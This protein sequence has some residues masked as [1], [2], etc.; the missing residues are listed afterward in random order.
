MS[1][2]WFIVVFGAHGRKHWSFESIIHF[3][4]DLLAF[5]F[6]L[7]SLINCASACSHVWS[8]C[9]D[10]KNL[11]RLQSYLHFFLVVFWAHGRKHRIVESVIHFESDVL[12]RAFERDGHWEL[13]RRRV[14]EVC[15]IGLKR[16]TL[17]TEFSLDFCF[18]FCF[19]GTSNGIS[20]LNY[21][22]FCCMLF[23]EPFEYLVHPFSFD[24]KQQVDLLCDESFYTYVPLK[25]FCD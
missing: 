14:A 4:R 21:I 19:S 8:H 5:T 16:C 24:L 6:S 13:R 25:P 17:H 22:G 23:P 1:L 15:A 9:V 3:E 20:N 10:P 2:P 11:K 12:S 18:H 7:L